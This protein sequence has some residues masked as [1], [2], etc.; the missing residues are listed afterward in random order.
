MP[1]SPGARITDAAGNCNSANWTVPKT[2]DTFKEVRKRWT[3]RILQLN[4][5]LKF[6]NAC[7]EHQADPFINDGDVLLFLQDLQVCFPTHHFDDTI[8][9][10]Q[11]FRLDLLHKLL[12]LSG[13][14]DSH[15]AI[16]LKEGTPSGAF[17]PLQPVGL[18]DQNPKPHEEPPDLQICQN[19]WS[20]ANANPDV[21]RSL[22]QQ[23][24]ENNFVQEIQDIDTA[25][26]RWTKG[27][28]LGKLGVVCA[29]NRD[30]RCVL[31]STICGMNGCCYLPEKQRLPNLR[32][33]SHFFS[34][35]PPLQEQWQDERGALLFQFENK[36]YAY[37]S[38]YFGAKTSAWHWGRVSGALL[39][40]VHKF[41]YFRHAAWVY[42]DDFLF[43]FPNS[44]A[45]VQFALAIILLQLIGAPL[46]WKKLEF[47]SSIEWNGWTIRPSQ[48]TESLAAFKAQKIRNL[49]SNLQ[50]QPCR[51]NLEKIIGIL[52]WSTSIIHYAR[53]R[54]ISLYRDLFAYSIDPTHWE[55][56]LDTLTDQR[57][58]HRQKKTLNRIQNYAALDFGPFITIALNHTT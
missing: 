42:V 53:F 25:E 56:F 3:S 22:I 47:G 13:D 57:S 48:M 1:I 30:P 52:L 15:I 4:L 23:E 46:S 45:P 7:S 18:G 49:V 28:A 35:C 37:R 38:A 16:L 31:D 33:V 40:L 29:D 19:N 58:K 55:H 43:L 36:T 51:K 12:T 27:A 24:V 2:I 11:P 9:P 14:P 54:L 32:H 10:L 26:R 41:M 21:T 8:L 34:T 50:Q 17:T 5:H 44:T 39:R 20:S 6:T